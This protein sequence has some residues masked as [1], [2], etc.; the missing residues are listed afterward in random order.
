MSKIV[1]LIQISKVS[2]R[3]S[4]GLDLSAEQL[5]DHGQGTSCKLQLLCICKASVIPCAGATHFSNVQ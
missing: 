2:Q 1:G 5:Q 4:D 3:V